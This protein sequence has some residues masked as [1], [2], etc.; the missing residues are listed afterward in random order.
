[1]DLLTAYLLGIATVLIILIP[2]WILARV[3]RVVGGAY[4]AVFCKNVK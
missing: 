4:N 3:N 1:M 2:W